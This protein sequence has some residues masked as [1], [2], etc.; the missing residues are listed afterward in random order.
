MCRGECVL[1][2]ELFIDKKIKEDVGSSLD[3]ERKREMWGRN[4]HAAHGINCVNLDDL[5][6]SEDDIQTLSKPRYG[7]LEALIQTQKHKLRIILSRVIEFFLLVKEGIL[8]Q[9]SY[10]DCAN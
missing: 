2:G 8:S 4:I 5:F 1:A 6:C 3:V 10:K 9:K 7:N